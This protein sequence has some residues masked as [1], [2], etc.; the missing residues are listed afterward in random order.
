[1]NTLYITL[2]SPSPLALSSPLLPASPVDG[3]SWGM[4]SCPTTLTH[5]FSHSIARCAPFCQPPS[6]PHTHSYRERALFS[7][8]LSPAPPNTAHTACTL[9]THMAPPPSHMPSFPVSLVPLEFA[10]G[11]PVCIRGM[12]RLPGECLQGPRIDQGC[13]TGRGQVPMCHRT[14][15]C[16]H[17]QC[18]HARLPYRTLTL[19]PTP[20]AS[21]PIPRQLFM[22]LGVMS[23]VNVMGGTCALALTHAR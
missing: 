18:Q 17:S 12:G 2:T 20:H 8:F 22:F 14:C 6:H 19:V 7:A 21:I 4:L 3:T 15:E 1:M 23:F 16:V 10:H 9:H 5:S 11:R 13:G